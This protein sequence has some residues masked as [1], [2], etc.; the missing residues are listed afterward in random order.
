M[1]YF[2]NLWKSYAPYFTDVWQYLII[3]IIFI[4]AGIVYLTIQ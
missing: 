2:K 3:I 1:S 4:I